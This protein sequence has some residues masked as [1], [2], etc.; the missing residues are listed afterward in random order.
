HLPHSVFSEAQM[1]LITWSHQFL[2]NEGVP[3]RSTM[4]SVEH[5]L[6]E[7]CGIKT[8]QYNGTF[9]HIYYVNDLHAIVTQEMANPIVC[10]H[11]EFFLEDSTGYFC[12]ANQFQWWRHE[13]NAD[14]TTPMIHSHNHDFYIYEPA[15]LTTGQL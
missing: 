3:N 14:L 9:G 15:L 10:Q 8:I 12:N 6:Q 4:K 1:S 2:G 11:L 7:M 13:L 5:F